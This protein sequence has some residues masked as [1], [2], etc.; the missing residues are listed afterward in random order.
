MFACTADILENHSLS[1]NVG[2]DTTH[3]FCTAEE[4]TVSISIDRNYTIMSGSPELKYLFTCKKRNDF[5][6]VDYSG[7]IKDTFIKK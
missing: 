6:S 2:G 3:G 1:V 7:C 5:L 4:N